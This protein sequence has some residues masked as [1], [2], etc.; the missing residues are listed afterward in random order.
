MLYD[1]TTDISEG[2]DLSK[3]DNINVQLMSDKLQNWE[4]TLMTPLWKEDK[5]WMDVTFHIHQMLMENKEV[6]FKQPSSK[7]KISKIKS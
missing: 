4:R 1:L 3:T 7:L 6:Q 2:N 5:P